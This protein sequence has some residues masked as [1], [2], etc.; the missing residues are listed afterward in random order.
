[1]E[2][3]I[4]DT[5]VWIDLFKNT[6]SKQ[7]ILLEEYVEYASQNLLLTPTIIQEILQGVK[8]EKDFIQK[9]LVL[10]SFNILKPDWEKTSIAAAK[11]Y[12]DLRKKGVTIRKSTDCL[13]AQVAIENNVLLVHNDTDFEL[14]AQNSTLRTFYKN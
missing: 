12:F 9:K 13:I 11:L 6:K 5:S 10:E 7:S 2:K 8:T 4:F 3:A 14:I 1:M